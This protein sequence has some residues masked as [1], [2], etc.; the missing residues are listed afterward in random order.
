MIQPAYCRTLARYNHWMN[1]KIYALCTGLSDAERREDRGAFFG[2]IHGTLDHLLYGDLAWLSR[3][4]GDPPALPRLGS[5]LH[6][7]YSD[8]RSARAAVD[9]RILEWSSALSSEWLA[10]PLQFTS[11]TDGIRRELPAWVLVVHMFNHQI[12]HRGQLTTLLA[13]LGLDPG[14]T[15][16]HKLPGLATV[17]GRSSA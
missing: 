4:T 16:L 11:Q 8:L 5:E 2:S 9:E 14:E 3:F 1:G 6:R 10:T 7:H 15:D 17:T 12:H 13:Q